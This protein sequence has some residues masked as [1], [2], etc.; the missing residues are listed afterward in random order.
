MYWSNYKY[1]AYLPIN[2]NSLLTNTGKPYAVQKILTGGL[3]DER[4]YQ[5]YS[6]PF[7]SAGALLDLGISFVFYPLTVTGVFLA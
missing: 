6:P 3:L 4:K 5:I 7:S 2:T 1:T